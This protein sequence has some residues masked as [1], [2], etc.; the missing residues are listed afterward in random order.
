MRYLAGPNP[1]SEGASARPRQGYR[2]LIEISRSA[3][4]FVGLETGDQA[5]VQAGLGWARSNRDSRLAAMCYCGTAVTL[6]VPTSQDD[7][8]RRRR[9]TAYDKCA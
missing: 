5:A 3:P 4:R 2:D 7:N 6:T 1:R 8:R 9:L